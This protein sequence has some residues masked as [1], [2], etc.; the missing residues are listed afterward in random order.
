M[1]VLKA[2]RGGL[3]S[4]A[5][6]D[7]YTSV[8]SD[9]TKDLGLKLKRMVGYQQAVLRSYYSKNPPIHYQDVLHKLQLLQGI[10]IRLA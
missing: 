10:W 1:K 4:I 3:S 2:T 9:R 7:K 6:N 8:I 5:L